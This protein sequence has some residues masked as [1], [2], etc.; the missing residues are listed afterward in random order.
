MVWASTSPESPGAAIKER[1]LTHGVASGEN[2]EM[3]TVPWPAV[4]NK[5][6]H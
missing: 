4:G 1:A 6:R 3:V 2:G 5:A